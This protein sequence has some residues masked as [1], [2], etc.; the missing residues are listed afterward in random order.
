MNPGEPAAGERADDLR[1]N[2]Q[3]DQGGGPDV[4]PG[5]VEKSEIHPQTREREEDRCEERSCNRLQDRPHLGQLVPQ[6]AEHDPDDERSEYRFE[7]ERLGNRA[8][9]EGGDECNRHRGGH[10]CTR[11]HDLAQ[12]PIQ[13]DPADRHG[14]HHE[15]HQAE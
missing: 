6:P 3:H 8:P 11:G 13:G 9:D 4:R 1:R 15:Q 14:Q 10:R 5:A 7:L 2:R 12:Q